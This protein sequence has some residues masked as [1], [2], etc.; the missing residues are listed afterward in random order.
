VQG[1]GYPVLPSVLDQHLGPKERREDFHV[2]KLIPQNNLGATALVS[3][4]DA[5]GLERLE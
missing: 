5:S 1:V 3:W 4:S 2:E